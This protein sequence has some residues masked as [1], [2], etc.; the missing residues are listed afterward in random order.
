VSRVEGQG[1]LSSAMKGAKSVAGSKLGKALAKQA[2][3]AGSKM[4]GNYIPPSVAN[5]IAE[6]AVSRVEGQGFLNNAIKGVV[7]AGKQVAKN[8]LVRA[9]ADAGVKAGTEAV[10]ES[11]RSLVPAVAKA[12]S[13]SGARCR[14]GKKTRGGA[15]YPAGMGVDVYYD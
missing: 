11:R 2:I 15:L 13:G 10:L 6:E 12:I 3:H 4:A 5:A 1:F 9:I 8:K 14:K 7:K